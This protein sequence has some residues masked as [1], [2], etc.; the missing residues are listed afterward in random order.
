MLFDRRAQLL[1]TTPRAGENTV[2]L[3]ALRFAFRCSAS[4]QRE[5]NA[6]EVTIYNAADQT[7]QNLQTRGAVVNIF[8]GYAA[9]PSLALLCH[10]DITY[11]TSRWEGT[12]RVTKLVLGDGARVLRDGFVSLSLA[13]G[14]SHGQALRVVCKRLGLPVPDGV[15]AL[16]TQPPG[17]ITLH[18]RATQVFDRL[19]RGAWSIQRGKLVV[20]AR[21]DTARAIV[22]NENAGLL[23]TPEYTRAQGKE[24]AKVAFKTLLFAQL[25]PGEVVKLE[26]ATHTG[27]VRVAS[28]TH[29]GD[30]GGTT[31]HTTVEGSPL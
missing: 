26:S 8:A 23:D 13:P 22:V 25:Q 24:G 20:S 30:T 15:D 1:V 9:S 5:P 14:T 4:K 6:A 3:S 12:D 17:G 10:G 7:I 16:T 28:V 31:W 27:F 2:D 29:E 21:Q 11:S 18:G 19:A